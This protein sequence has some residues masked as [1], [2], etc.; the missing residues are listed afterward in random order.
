[1][2]KTPRPQAPGEL[3]GGVRLHV[4]MKTGELCGV[5]FAG[6]FFAG[7]HG[8]PSTVLDVSLSV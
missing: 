6:V 2:D 5:F 4:D 1:M 8:P 3:S 7:V